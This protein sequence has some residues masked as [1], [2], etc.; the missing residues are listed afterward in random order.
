MTTTTIRRAKSA[1]FSFYYVGLGL[2]LTTAA[3]MADP[4]A[5]ANWIA[6]ALLPRD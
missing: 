2:L 3:T 6:D 4:R 1:P 5:A